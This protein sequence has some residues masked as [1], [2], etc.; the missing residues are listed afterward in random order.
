MEILSEHYHGCPTT[1]MYVYGGYCI[2]DEEGCGG[3][4]SLRTI[5]IYDKNQERRLTT[6]IDVR[7]AFVVKN[8]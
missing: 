2:A 1:G 4:I 8:L 6:R 3:G 7:K 5:S